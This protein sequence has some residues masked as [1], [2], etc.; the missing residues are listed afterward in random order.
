MK[1]L[2]FTALA[3]IFGNLC[4]AEVA[5]ADFYVS[6]EGSDKWSG[7]KSDSVKGGGDGP[8]ASL[9]RARDAV[10]DLKKTRDGDILL[11]G[12]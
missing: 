6:T 2:I 8:F 12:G 5:Q 7:T 4:D 10:R 3:L 1:Q 9:K 11:A